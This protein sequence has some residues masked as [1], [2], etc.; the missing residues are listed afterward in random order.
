MW[1]TSALTSP[2]L[3]ALL[4][5]S[6]ESRVAHQSIHTHDHLHLRSSGCNAA[7]MAWVSPSCLATRML[8][9]NGKG[10]LSR[11]GA[12]FWRK[13]VRLASQKA[14]PV[15]EGHAEQSS[16]WK[17]LQE[18]TQG[19]TTQFDI[20]L[21]RSNNRIE[22]ERQKLELKSRVSCQSCRNGLSLIHISEPTRPRLI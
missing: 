15:G 5:L 19:R 3:L 12:D 11:E 16:T 2:L 20:L 22:V 13:R 6:T 7:G 21:K 10:S 14:G 4:A 18:K 9:G 8:D 1:S 17:W